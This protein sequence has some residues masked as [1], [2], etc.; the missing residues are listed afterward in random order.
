RET[1]ARMFEPFFT[2]KGQG[3][4]TGL[5]LATVYGI[6]KQSDGHI[7]VESEPGR[8]TA[9]QIYLPIVDEPIQTGEPDKPH[10]ALPYGTETVLLV[11]DEPIVRML[12]RDT[13]RLFGYTVLEARHGFEAQLIGS[14]C[15]G[16]ID[17]LM[18]DVVMPQMSGKELAEGLL[19]MH[20]EMKVLYMSGYTENAMIDNGILDSGRVF[21][22]KPF[23]PEVLARKVRDI[24]D[25]VQ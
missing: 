17:V 25:S 8:G 7:V 21:L 13:L 16:R 18:T 5:G 15:A 23:T 11:E 19:Q 6:V 20:P 22:Q 24:I 14:Q 2:T 4:G 9:F 12:I 10:I 3:K 1:Q